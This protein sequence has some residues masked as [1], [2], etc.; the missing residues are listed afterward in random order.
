MS[1]ERLF[2]PDLKN[3]PVLV[4]SSNDGCV[5]SRSEEVKQM[6]VSMGIPYFQIE[7]LCRERDIKVFS[8]NFTLYRD[9]SR[10]VMSALS[11]HVDTVEVYSIDEAFFGYS[12][13]PHL[14]EIEEIR[15]SII[16]ATG[17]PVSIGVSSTK[18]L[19]KIA[20]RDANKG[21]GIAFLE[22]DNLEERHGDDLVGSVWGIGRQAAARL[23]ERGILTIRDYM[24][25]EDRMLRQILGISGS[26]IKSELSGVKAVM[27]QTHTIPVS[28][29]STR[30]FGKPQ[31]T[32]SGVMGALSHHAASLGERLRQD[33]LMTHR[34][35]A[36][37]APSRFGN[38]SQ[39]SR[40]LS[41][42]I[43]PTDSTAVLIRE[44][45]TLIGRLFVTGVPYARGGIVL[46]ELTPRGSTTESFFDQEPNG[47]RMVSGIDHVIDAINARIG[48]TALQYGVVGTTV[49]WNAKH[50]YSSPRYT[51]RWG[52]IPKVHAK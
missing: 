28:I 23:R 15:A 41:V 34:I 4:L 46:G 19:A 3:K 9:I 31:Q 29:T 10:R 50:A 30:S 27:S 11:E 44:I 16:H 8:S 37:I 25:T 5:V 47:D 32:I 49:T 35:N 18:T 12:F 36:F 52:D 17:I 2:R 48:K 43:S 13:T 7:K 26:R 1:C 40:S 51:T 21:V 42:T 38:F 45:R 20:N 39:Q 6:G 24:H 22:V 14:R 33:G